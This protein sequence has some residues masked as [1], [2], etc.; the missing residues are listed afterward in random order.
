MTRTELSEILER[1][2]KWLARCRAGTLQGGI[3]EASYG[4]SWRR[5]GRS[6]KWVSPSM[7]HGVQSG[8]LNRAGI[9]GWGKAMN[10]LIGLVIGILL[11]AAV[12]AMGRGG[13]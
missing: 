9:D 1:H 2:R 6:G 10:F 8:V 5:G 11:G 4:V 7:A 12:Y 3:T 13:K